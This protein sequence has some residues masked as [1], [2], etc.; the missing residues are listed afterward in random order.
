M[1]PQAKTRRC[2]AEERNCVSPIRVGFG[3]IA[4]QFCNVCERAGCYNQANLLDRNPRICPAYSDGQHSD[5]GIA[6][7]SPYIR[8]LINSR[9]SAV[10]SPKTPPTRNVTHYRKRWSWNTRSVTRCRPRIDVP[11]NA[12]AFC[13]WRFLFVDYS[14]RC[15]TSFNMTMISHWPDWLIV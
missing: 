2:D 9:L 6:A 11:G 10:G 13:R 15:F 7:Q 8:L 1:L 5:R 4:Q 12:G 14:V 3:I